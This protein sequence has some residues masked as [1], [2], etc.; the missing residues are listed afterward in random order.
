VK[1][2]SLRKELEVGGPDQPSKGS[3]KPK[4]E[5]QGNAAA[6]ENCNRKFVDLFG[7]KLA[8]DVPRLALTAGKRPVNTYHGL[9]TTRLHKNKTPGRKPRG[10]V[11]DSAL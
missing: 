4:P 11:F 2:A 1:V 3:P 5:P 7:K 8:V 9:K 10:F 6:A